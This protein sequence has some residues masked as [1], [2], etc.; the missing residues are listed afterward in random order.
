MKIVN[1]NIVHCKIF[2]RI[3]CNRACALQ[4]KVATRR[5]EE[6]RIGEHGTLVGQLSHLD[7]VVLDE[8]GYVGVRDRGLFDDS[9]TLEKLIG[10][11]PMSLRE[12]I[13]E[14]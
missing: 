2:C 9:K 5:Q 12:I 14:I 1:S 3:A 11:S 4:V 7:L 10:R 6:T 8:L 13:A